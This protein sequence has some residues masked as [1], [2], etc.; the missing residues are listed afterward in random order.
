MP[1]PTMASTDALSACRDEF[2]RTVIAAYEY[3]KA[4]AE[5]DRSYA[6]RDAKIE[7][8]DGSY[9]IEW[10]GR[11]DSEG[12]VGTFDCVVT[13]NDVSVTRPYDPWT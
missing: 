4:S 11:T 10:P 13:N 9:H 3:D 5:F 7:V 6:A 8:V 1:P 12:V 2:I